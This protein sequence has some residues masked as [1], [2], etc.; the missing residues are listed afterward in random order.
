MN[1][2]WKKIECA[3]FGVKPWELGE[4]RWNKLVTER[5]DTISNDK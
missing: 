5:N 3:E 2:V 4:E 1:D